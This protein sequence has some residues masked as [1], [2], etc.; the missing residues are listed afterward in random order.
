MSGLKK[1][2]LRFFSWITSRSACKINFPVSTFHFPPQL[3]S[4]DRKKDDIKM[5]TKEFKK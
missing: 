3:I 1:I 5:S 2:G 4:F